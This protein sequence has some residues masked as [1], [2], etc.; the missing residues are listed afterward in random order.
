M[1]FT[2]TLTQVNTALAHLDDTDGTPGSDTITVNASDSFGN[3]A[4]AADDGDHGE[5]PAGDHRAVHRDGGAE[6]GDGGVWRQRLG[7]R[8]HGGRDLHRRR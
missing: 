3:T 5:R 4:G 2:G 1:T 7:E 8:Q 6:H